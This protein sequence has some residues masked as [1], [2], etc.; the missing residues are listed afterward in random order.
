[1]S[2]LQSR[3]AARDRHAAQAA[4]LQAAEGT[5]VM[6]SLRCALDW[7][8][9]S[10]NAKAST[11]G[12]VYPQVKRTSEPSLLEPPSIARHRADSL[13]D[14]S[15]TVRSC[16]DPPLDPAMPLADRRRDPQSA[17]DQTS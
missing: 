2:C 7:I 17:Q 3:R 16:S 12:N 5:S 10:A 15:V 6:E 4:S 11:D 9:S 8:D 14:D 1:M 13:E